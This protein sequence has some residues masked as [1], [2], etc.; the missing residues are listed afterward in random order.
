M[1][2]YLTRNM[3]RQLL[4]LL[5]LVSGLGLAATP[6]VAAQASVVSVAAAGDAEDCQTIASQPLEFSRGVPSGRSEQTP[7]STRP[8][9][10]WTPTVQ[11]QADRA[12]E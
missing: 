12:R 5:A 4:T 10:V 2:R 1:S 8:I 11:L 9:I 6:A 3:L 7:C